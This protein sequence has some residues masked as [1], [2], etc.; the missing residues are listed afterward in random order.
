[1]II[2]NMTGGMNIDIAPDNIP[3]QP[4]EQLE[5]HYWKKQYV[6]KLTKYSVWDYM[7]KPWLR[8]MENGGNNR[9]RLLRKVYKNRKIVGYFGFRNKAG[10]NT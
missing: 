4:M 7:A 1:M 3:E 6:K 9:W 10:D 2:F 5:C 8:V